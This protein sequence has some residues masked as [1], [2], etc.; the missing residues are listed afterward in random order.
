MEDK[1]AVS[2]WEGNAEAWTKLSRAGYDVYRDVLNTPCFLG[3]L[4]DV[5][6]LHGVDIGCGEGHNTRL[7]AERCGRITGLDPCPTFIRY[8]REAEAAE[9]RGI[10]YVEASA[11][12]LPF[13]DGSFDFATAF[14]SFM[15][16]AS[17]EAAVA[18]AYRVI[19]P[20]GFFQLSITH[21]CYDTPYRRNLRKDG[22]T[23]AVE[24]GGYF[25][26]M[27]GHIEEW[28][29][30]SA[31]EEAKRG[32]AKFKVPRFRR[33]LSQWMNL[34]IDTGFAIERLAEPS[35]DD[36]TAERYPKVQDTQVVAYFLHMRVRKPKS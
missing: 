6:G 17:P 31:P 24:I 35:V 1:E 20:G 14:M 36:E 8:A 19:A 11:M 22:K 12:K 2:Y 7:L 23:Y 29:F 10:D 33:T 18:E 32:L 3:M 34:F 13:A 9:P 16:I 25:D 26:P 30:G 15:D 27:D 21:P 4:P 28:I 5:A